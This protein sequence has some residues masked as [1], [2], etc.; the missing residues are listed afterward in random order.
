MTRSEV[1]LWSA[2]RGKQLNGLRF[3]RQ[4]PMGPYVVD[5]F[6]PSARLVVE[7]DG[8]VHGTE[9]GCESDAA[10]DRRIEA[11]GVRILRIPSQLVLT[12]MGRALRV[13]GEAAGAAP[14]R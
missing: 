4:H 10:R 11:S 1:A 3:R 6:C 7:V 9:E 8:E 2:L 12:D 14:R 13:I 5:F